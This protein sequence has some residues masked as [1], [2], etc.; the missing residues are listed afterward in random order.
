MRADLFLVTKGYAVSRQ[1]AKLLI[2]NGWVSQNGKLIL[3]PSES[4][5]ES[6]GPIEIRQLPPFVGRGGEKLEAAIL[7]FGVD[8]NEVTAV[9]IGASTGGFTDCL[10]QHG[11]KRVFAVDSGEGQLAEKLRSDSRV[12]SLE[13]CN[14]RD[15]SFETIGEKVSL[16]VM[17][18]SF[19]SATYIIP[20]FPG[21]LNFDGEAICLIK[22]QFEVGRALVGKK[23]IVKDPSAHRLAIERVVQSG[24][25]TGLTP[26]GLISSPIEGGD[27][28]REFL[29]DF[30]LRPNRPELED[31]RIQEV[32]RC[33][34]GVN[35]L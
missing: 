31:S 24:K 9:D 1:Q 20:R 13:R 16:I 28:N 32:I 22:P 14:A 18:V 5:S 26:V 21:L 15:L 8:V 27:G 29:I 34:R 19:I 25:E 3:K 7:A 11:A 30:Q 35:S 10:L 33:G 23:G 4:L 6:D 12:I 17:D 2:S